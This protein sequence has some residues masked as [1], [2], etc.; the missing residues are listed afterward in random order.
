MPSLFPN[1]S[2]EYRVRRV[3]ATATRNRAAAADGVGGGR[4]QSVATWRRGPRGLPVRSHGRRRRCTTVRMSEL[5]GRER[6]ADDLP[7]HVPAP[8]RRMSAGANDA[9]PL[10]KFRCEEGPVPVLHRADRHVGRHD[11]SFRRLG[12]QPRGVSREPRSSALRRSRGTRAGGTSELLSARAT[13]FAATMAAMALMVS[14][15]RS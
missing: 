3:R 7:L 9:A 10:R 15:S 13:V 2:R 4:T 1:E 14:P 6:H 11:A 5:F 8:R 12:G